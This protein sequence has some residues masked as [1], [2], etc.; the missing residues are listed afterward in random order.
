MPI[1][2]D[3]T[4]CDPTEGQREGS[5]CSLQNNTFSVVRPPRL[6]YGRVPIR[7]PVTWRLSRV[8]WLFQIHLITLL[9]HLWSRNHSPYDTLKPFELDLES[10]L[11]FVALVLGEYSD[12][13]C[14]VNNQNR[15]KAAKTRK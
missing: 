15:L 4:Q 2:V 7:V 3:T 11:L 13:R 9:F 12:L 8:L 1:T 14:L 6:S 5:V 10:A